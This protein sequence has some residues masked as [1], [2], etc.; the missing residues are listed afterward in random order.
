MSTT[1]AT[2]TTAYSHH[3]HLLFDFEGIAIQSETV[4]DALQEKRENKINC[5]ESH[6]IIF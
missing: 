4:I 2:M 1:T 3:G 6:R 5:Q